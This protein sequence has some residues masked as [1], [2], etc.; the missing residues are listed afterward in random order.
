MDTA[1]PGLPCPKSGC[2]RDLGNCRGEDG[3]APPLAYQFAAAVPSGAKAG[4]V[5]IYGMMAKR[6]IREKPRSILSGAAFRLR[7][8]G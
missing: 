6:P 2:R 4:R 7:A 3:R 8:A 1:V 5:G